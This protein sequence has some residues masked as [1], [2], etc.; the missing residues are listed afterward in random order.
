MGNSDNVVRGGMTVKHIDVEELLAVLDFEPL[1][2]PVVE[3]TE[4]E[5]GRWRYETPNTPFVMSRVEL[6]DDDHRRHDA[7]RA[8]S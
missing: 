5:P 2:D 3:R 7:P 4:I 8:A 6:G 1:P